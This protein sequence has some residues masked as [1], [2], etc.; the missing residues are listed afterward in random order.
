MKKKIRLTEN[1]IAVI[2]RYL[3][4]RGGLLM[5]TSLSRFYK[6][7]SEHDTAIITAFRD[8]D[9]ECRSGENTGRKLTKEENLKRNK[10]LKAALLKLGYGVTSVSGNYIEGKNTNNEVE[11]GGNS[12]FVV[13]TNDEPNFI[14]N[15]ARLGERYCQDSVIIILKGGKNAFLMG[16]NNSE[17]IG[18][19]NVIRAG[20]FTAG[21][22][23][24]DDE[25]LTR[26]GGRPVV[27]KDREKPDTRSPNTA[28]DKEYSW[29]NRAM[30]AT[31]DAT[32]LEEYSSKSIREKHAIDLIS[33]NIIKEI[34]R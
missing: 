23:G 24:P 5:E 9:V 15:I 19:G 8:K 30:N 12:F 18:Y 16:T 22:V 26:V 20:D 4:T 1:Q 7:I 28:T 10:E 31:N 32:K 13:N 3:K 11:V 34:T 6:H 33:K 25:F 21:E 2:T 29:R 27:F 14:E 17:W